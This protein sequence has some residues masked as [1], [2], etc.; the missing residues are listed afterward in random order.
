[1]MVEPNILSFSNHGCHGTYN[2]I[3]SNGLQERVNERHLTEQNAKPSDHHKEDSFIFDPYHARH[4]K[5]Q[6]YIEAISDISPGEEIFSD[7]LFFSDK[8][9]FYEEVQVLKRIC[10][11]EEIGLI[12]KSEPSDTSEC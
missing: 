9:A 8:E 2:V 3:D 5:H 7:Y 1:M 10:N 11:G 6:G 4:L 12:A